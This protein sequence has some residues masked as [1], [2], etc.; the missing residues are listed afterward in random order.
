[1]RALFALIEKVAP[2]DATVLVTGESGTG[3]ELVAEAIHRGSARKSGPF[4]A[5]NS[6]ALTESAGR[7]GALRPRAGRIHRG[8]R[9]ARAGRFELANGGTL[10]LD[11]VAQLSARRPGEAPARPR[12]ARLRAGRRDEDDPRRH[13]ARRG[14]ERGPGAARSGRNVPRRPLLS[15]EHGHPEDSAAPGSGARTSRSSWTSSPRGP[16][17][18]T[19]PPED[20]LPDLE[21]LARHPF[22]GNVRELEHLVE[23]VTVLVEEDVIGPE[24]FPGS[25][26]RGPAAPAPPRDF[27]SPR[28]CPGSSGTSSSGRS[29]LPEA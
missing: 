29:K 1:M 22:R 21:A 24:H 13:P 3:K 9:A 11:E 17:R 26:G 16:P 10:F 19:P 18:A 12:A 6:S 8:G 5:V 25:L 23:M 20:V 14:H 4:V 27:R 2:T 7:V 28:P 15:S